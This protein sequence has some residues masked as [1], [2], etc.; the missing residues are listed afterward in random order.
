MTVAEALRRVQSFNRLQEAIQIVAKHPEV[1]EDYVRIQLRKGLG[2]DGRTLLL[3]RDDPY[4]QGNI[5][6][7]EGYAKW[8]ASLG[9]S[10]PEKEY[11]A[12]DFFINGYTHSYITVKVVG[13]KAMFQAEVPWG[14]D[15]E[16]KTMGRAFG[17]A[18]DSM[19]HYRNNYM[20]PE[21]IKAFKLKT[22]LG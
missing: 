7:A 10:D 11:G 15:I 2:R 21:L 16:S 4:F 8:K 22:G 1:V 9:R 13:D 3:Y 19:R 20:L 5:A 6:W 14:V 12:A 17:L 18:P